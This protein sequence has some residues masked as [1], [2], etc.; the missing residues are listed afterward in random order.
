MVLAA[1]IGMAMMRGDDPRPMVA[2]MMRIADMLE[3][4]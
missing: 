1:A 3:I 4:D 2:V